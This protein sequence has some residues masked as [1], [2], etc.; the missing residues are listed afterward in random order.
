MRNGPRALMIAQI[1][2]GVVL[3]VGGGV[4]LFIPGPGLPLIVFGLALIAGVSK[5]LARLLDRMEPPVRRAGQAAMARWRALP[6]IAKV[7]LGVV[8]AAL[9]AAFAYGMYRLWFA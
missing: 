7:G 5:P 3:V 6:M 2:L 1:V 8:A 4:F 9:T